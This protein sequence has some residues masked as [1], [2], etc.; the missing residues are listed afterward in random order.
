MLA[1]SQFINVT[2]PPI[3]NSCTYTVVP[4]DNTICQLRVDFS[5]LTLSQPSTDGTCNVDNIQISGGSSPVPTICGDNNGQHVYVAF[6]GTSS[7]S[8]TV[9]TTAATSFNRVWN[10][11]LSLISCTSAYAAPAGCLQYYLDSSGIVQ[12]F[13]Y[14]STANPTAGAIVGTRQMPNLNY[15]I[16]IRS[17]A[18]QCSITYTPVRIGWF[19]IWEH[20]ITETLV[21][22][23]STDLFA[24]TLTGD[25]PASTAMVGTAA[26]GMQG[27]DCTTDYL[28]IPNPTTG[29]NDRFCGM[30][31]A[32][33][34]S[35]CCLVCKVLIRIFS[36]KDFIFF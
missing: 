8:I 3:F 20:N 9:S 27:A 12:S 15:G 1:Y 16:C 35:E 26:G 4:P 29:A 34:T 7:I 18:G 13:N 32:A 33:T 19:Y 24:F 2:N 6:S 10:L 36:N 11:Q 14:G 25:V 21:Q 28:I 17:G 5:A 30:G 23:P 22:Q 31:I